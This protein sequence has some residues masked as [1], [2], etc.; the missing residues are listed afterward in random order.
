MS[1]KADRAAAKAEREASRV[2]AKEERAAAK[3]AMVASVKAPKDASVDVLIE[4]LLDPS[5]SETKKL[6]A[7][8]QIQ[9]RGLYN[10][11]PD[12]FNDKLADLFTSGC[13]MNS[14]IGEILDKDSTIL[15]PHIG[16]I[17]DMMK[18]APTKSSIYLTHLK[19]LAGLHP[20]AVFEHIEALYQ[21]T[22][23]MKGG[24]VIEIAVLDILGYMNGLP[25]DAVDRLF[26]MT[27]SI[28]KGNE[29]EKTVLSRGLEQVSNLKENLSDRSVLEK[30]MEF[31]KSCRDSNTAIFT[32]IEDYMAGRSLENVTSRLDQHEAWLKDQEARLNSLAD[33]FD[34]SQEKMLEMT[35]KISG[36]TAS[37]EQTT[38]MLNMLE[39]INAVMGDKLQEGKNAAA[40]E[41]LLDEDPYNRAFYNSFRSELTATYLAAKSVQTDIVTNS[42]TGLGGSV[43]EVLQTASSYI[44]VIGAGVKFFGAVISA[45]DANM[46]SKMVK[47]YADIAVDTDEMNQIS[48]S[49]AAA[50]VQSLDQEKLN[51]PES[52]MEKCKNLLQFGS[53]FV[54]GNLGDGGSVAA[55][56]SSTAA[57]FAE[58]TAVD[59]IASLDFKSFFSRKPKVPLSAAEVA[60]MKEA[61]YIAERKTQG[62]DDAGMVAN[63]IVSYIY[64]G[65]LKRDKLSD[66]I[67]DLNSFAM[68]EFGKKGTMTST[69]ASTTTPSDVNVQLTSAAS[70][71]PAAAASLASTG[72]GNNINASTSQSSTVQSKAPVK[73]EAA[74]EEENLGYDASAHANPEPTAGDG[75]CCIIS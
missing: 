7:T 67:A 58:N 10:E 68:E 36:L 40:L 1:S 43:G 25:A 13:S 71:S 60:A 31:L 42:K 32:T 49:L 5:A 63:T 20:T 6:T 24:A 47:R 50:L 69:T 21:N 61:Q 52:M 22:R 34:L 29:K 44:P 54:N 59:G 66:K 38:I 57:N 11:N 19:K 33:K 62:S 4:I 73:K 53:D 26:G 30:E 72:A 65:K 18:G 12:L 75:G 48:R 39:E 23:G 28:M 74:K 15:L 16:A 37:D 56:A 64:S 41:K 14:L 17:V 27:V 70:P 2:A 9:K 35:D 8:G 45:V 46:Q 55:I 51:K 3:D